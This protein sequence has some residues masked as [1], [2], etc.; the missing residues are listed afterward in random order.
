[1]AQLPKI[2]SLEVR[3]ARHGDCLLLHFGTKARPQLAMIDGGADSTYADHLRPR[4]MALRQARGL[5]PQEPLPVDLLMVTH[6]DADHLK[7]VLDLTRELVSSNVAPFVQVMSFWHNSF[8]EII[9]NTPEELTAA[10]TAQFGTASPSGSVPDDATL[11]TAG[12]LHAEVV[13]DT[14]KVLASIEQGE[15][16]KKDAER[17][18][19]SLNAEFDG[20]LILAGAQKVTIPRQSRGLSFCEPLK[21]A[22]RGR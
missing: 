1:M 22:I 7:G 2:F 10:L 9:G 5:G 6:V 3:R 20:K 12:D 14:L 19:F 4:L 21:A 15:R 17:L 18:G 16:L 8:D 13:R 11:D